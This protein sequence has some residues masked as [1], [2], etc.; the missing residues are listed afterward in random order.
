M[1]IVEQEKERMLKEHA[2]RLEGFLHPDLVER[3]RKVAGYDGT[4][5]QSPHYL[6]KYT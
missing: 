5:P 3:A 1:R 4:R 2:G 6:Q